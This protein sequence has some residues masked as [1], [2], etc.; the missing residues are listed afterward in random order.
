MGEGRRLK[1]WGPA[2]PDSYCEGV[3]ADADVL[4]AYCDWLSPGRLSSCSSNSVRSQRASRR[5]WR[6]ELHAARQPAC[7]GSVGASR[8]RSH[9]VASSSE[10]RVC[11]LIRGVV[12]A[13]SAQAVYRTS[14]YTLQ[15]TR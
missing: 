1:G 7:V 15:S 12:E 14:N 11:A 5:G 13:L 6:P 8:C 4:H 10:F 9:A 2:R 3:V